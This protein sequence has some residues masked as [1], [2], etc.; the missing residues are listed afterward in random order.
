LTGQGYL[1]KT[2]DYNVLVVTTEGRRVLKGEVV[3]R[4]L[5][6]TQKPQRKAKVVTD[7]WQGVD[8]GLFEALRKVR[9]TLARERGVPAFVI[10]GDTA[11]RDM[12]RRRPS[13]VQRFLAVKG[14]GQAKCTQYGRIMVE[15][16]R[17]YCL[18][19]SLEMDLLPVD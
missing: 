12:A 17:A 14:V 16:I 18:E 6:P 8:K 19:H 1:E 15:R 10:F 11:L 3:P 7:A 5:R 9:A 2:G 4:L 13:T